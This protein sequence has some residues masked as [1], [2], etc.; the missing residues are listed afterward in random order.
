MAKRGGWLRG[1]EDKKEWRAKRGRGPK[2]AE[3]RVHKVEGPRGDPPAMAHPSGNKKKPR[4]RAEVEGTEDEGTEAEGPTP[5][6]QDEVEGP[7]SRGQGQ[8]AK[9]RATAMAPPSRNKKLRKRAKIEGPRS[10]GPRQRVLMVEEGASV[11]GRRSRGPRSMGPRS[12]GQGQGG[13]GRGSE[14]DRC[15]SRGQGPG[16]RG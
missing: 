5:W 10:R 12:R 15:R 16:D 14:V 7:R 3:G 11:D 4:K 2:E 8:G 9:G 6:C 1:A 13:C